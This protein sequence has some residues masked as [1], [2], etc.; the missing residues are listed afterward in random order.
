MTD[1]NNKLVDWDSDPEVEV[2]ELESADADIH[3]PWDPSQI[4]VDPKMFSLKNI[5]DMINEDDLELAP[6]FQRKEVWGPL[7]KSRLIESLLLRIPLPAFYFSASEDGKYQVVDGLQRLS[8]V[9]DFVKNRFRL[10]NLEY[11]SDEANGKTYRDLEGTLWGRRVNST[12]IHVNVID[13]QTPDKVKFDIFKRINTGGSPLNAQ[14]IRHCMGRQPS[15]DLLR[16]CTELPS[17][18]EA[19]CGALQNHRRMVDREVALRFV[20]FKTMDE[21]DYTKAGTMDAFLT[22]ATRRID[23]DFSASDISALVDGFDAAMANSFRVFGDRAFRKW[24]R[25]MDKR[26]PINRALFEVWSVLLS[27]DNWER[28]KPYAE[29]IVNA[30]RDMMKDDAR[31]IEAISTATGDVGRMKYRFQAVASLL[32]RVQHD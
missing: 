29:D 1:E 17:F 6:P 16:T 5:I 27:N 11:L 23:E 4:R 30:S 14:E 22:E 10:T 32:K 19:T 3:N 7:Q 9:R 25:G 18:Q 26:F 2:E 21:G 13:P 28:L 15:R 31:F 12:Q 20:A 8:T 24:P